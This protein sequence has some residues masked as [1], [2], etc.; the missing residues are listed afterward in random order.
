VVHT[1]FW[2]GKVR[3]EDYLEDPHIDERIILKRMFGKWSGDMDWVDPTEDS[4]TWRAVV[5]AVNNLRVS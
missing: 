4:D 5:N 1:G 2:W 3:K